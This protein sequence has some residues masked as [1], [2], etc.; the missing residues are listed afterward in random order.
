MKESKLKIALLSLFFLAL[1]LFP[2]FVS[3]ASSIPN[4]QSVIQTPIEPP[5]NMAV[6]IVSVAVDSIGLVNV[7]LFFSINSSSWTSEMMV[8]IDGD[9]YNGTFLASIPGQAVGTHVSYYVYS[10]DAFGYSTES[11]IQNYTVTKDIKQ[12]H[13]SGIEIVEPTPPHITPWD[14]VQIRAQIEDEGSGVENATLLYGLS[15]PYDETTRALFSKAPM[16]LTDGDKYNG[17]Y[18]GEIPPQ[19]NNTI[20]WYYIEANDVPGNKRTSNY[21]S[22]EVFLST[23][24]SFSVI[25][26]IAEIDIKD[27][28]ATLNVFFYARLP[29]PFEQGVL[30]VHAYNARRNQT[31]AN[32]DIFEVNLSPTERFWYQSTTT[33]K[34]SLRGNP[35]CF[36]YDRYTLELTFVAWWS[37]IDDLQINDPFFNDYRLNFVWEDPKILNKATNHTSQYPEVSVSL[38][39]TRNADDRLPVILPILALFFMLGATLSVDS[40]KHLRS[41]LTVYLTSFV[42]IVGFFYTLGSWIPLRFGFTIAELMVITLTLGTVALVVSSFISASLSEHRR[43]VLISTFTDVGAVLFILILSFFVFRV[44]YAQG[45]LLSIPIS[46]SI[47]VVVGVIYGLAI[48]IYLNREQLKTQMP[49]APEIAVKLKAEDFKLMAIIIF[50]SIACIGVFLLPL[51]IR[52]MLKVRHAIFNPITY[53]TASFVHDY[54]QGLVFNLLVFIIFSVFTYSINKKVDKQ[55]FFFFS[56]LMMLVVLPLSSYSLLYYFDIWG[57][58]EFGSGLSLVDSGL[59]GFAVP[60]LILFFKGN[61]EKFNSILFFFSM[62]FLTL[63]LVILPYAATSFML[64]L[65]VLCA[66]LGFAL[67]ILEFRKI[68]AFISESLKQRETFAESYI[69]VLTLLFYF[70]SILSLFPADIVL[71]GGPIDI[72]SHYIGLLFGILPFSFYSLRARSLGKT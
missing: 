42:F 68:L 21:G 19:Q 49:Q 7:S 34:V 28:S 66:I 57:S 69:V 3:G 53:I 54:F 39:L 30:V 44:R 10:L 4:I 14:S 22:Y 62:L 20:V 25:V 13:I 72:V 61:L 11:V 38:Q 16:I 56:L 64:L 9:N 33:W 45:L 46:D 41:R 52:N 63:C 12:P 2:P 24:S 67:G 15:E 36:P 26:Q 58:I 59:I 40:K 47:L 18:V 23:W 48:R 35:N 65:L 55:R 6:N 50:V 37:K 27:L 32:F 31:Y 60:S 8:L 43:Q 5:P 17:T 51:E 70:I 71:K 1:C 29:S